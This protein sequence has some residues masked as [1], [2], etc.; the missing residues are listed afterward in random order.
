MEELISILGEIKDELSLMNE[1]LE[2]ISDNIESIRGIGICDSIA[3]VND[4]LDSIAGSGVCN[5]I[6]DI[7]DK[8]ESIGDAIESS[9]L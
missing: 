5:S 8:L 6:S 2:E 9:N 1:K 4:K 3:D 7:C